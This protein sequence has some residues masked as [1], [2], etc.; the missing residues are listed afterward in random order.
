MTIT[1]NG[2]DSRPVAPS[3]PQLADFGLRDGDLKRLTFRRML[4]AE[5]LPTV[6]IVVITVLAIWKF[7][8]WGIAVAVAALG[9]LYAARLGVERWVWSRLDLAIRDYD[10]AMD[11]YERARQAHDDAMETWEKRHRQ[12]AE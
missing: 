12:Q 3:V 6:G 5:E 7:G 10:L 1:K 4:L 8:W 11:A 2:D 9:L